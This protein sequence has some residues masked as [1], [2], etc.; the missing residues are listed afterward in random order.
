MAD[1]S[2]EIAAFRSAVY[3]EEVR[4]SMVSL[5]EKLNDVSEDTESTVNRFESDITS[6]IDA[7]NT[8]ASNANSKASAANTAA[9]SAN[10][11]ASSARSAATDAN[12]A[13][14]SANNAAAAASA[15]NTAAS[16]AETARV[17]AE[18]A[19]VNA[20]S[21]RESNE[22]NRQG[23]EQTRV[24]SESSRTTAEAS[25]ATNEQNR[26]TAEGKRESA[27]ATR[28]SNEN[29]RVAEFADMEQAFADMQKQVIPQATTSTMGGVI[30]G[31]GLDV[32][33]ARLSLALTKGMSGVSIATETA[34]ALAALTVYGESIQ[35]GTPTPDTPV[36]V[37]VVEGRNL[38]DDSSSNWGVSGIN[39]DTGAITSSSNRLTSELI[40]VKPNTT[41]T[42]S[43]N[44]DYDVINPYQY[45]ADGVTYIK[46]SFFNWGKVRTITTNAETAYVRIMLRKSDN[47]NVAVIDAKAAKV[48]LE[49]GSTATP[50]TPYGSIGIVTG[51]TATPIDLQGNMLA[52]LPDGTHDRLLVDSAGHVVIEQNT[53]KI[54]LN[55]SENIVIANND[56]IAFSTAQNDWL[57]NLKHTLVSANNQMLSNRFVQNQAGLATFPAGA[58][59]ISDTLYIKIEGVTTVDAAKTWLQD[60][61][62]YFIAP[63]ATPEHIDLGYI[64]MPTIESGDAI[65][66]SA[67]IVPVIDATWWERGAGA[68]ADAIKA[69]MAAL[70]AR[71]GE[72]A[73]AIA[74]IT[75][76]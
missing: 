75:N 10:T 34:E 32:D 14:T 74:D 67:S 51:D 28:V 60:N 15:T 22:Q 64:D 48:Q 62:P 63:L 56:A 42:V 57:V 39:G 50:Y 18:N 43:T 73:E 70:E 1:I 55:G 58:I 17:A 19:R 13:A 65:S 47:S 20:E 2:A 30:V 33:E 54:T 16:N 59:K 46:G 21:V 76:G 36:E 11:A 35:D 37:Q 40:A 31:D 4:G 27:E 41:Y 29:A 23:N 26:Q 8:A 12:S 52:S 44:D 38:L 5:A 68:V 53:K 6:S 61:Q 71:T 7:A 3:G 9:S 25:R 66:V 69:I 45:K 24:S 49:F 72:L